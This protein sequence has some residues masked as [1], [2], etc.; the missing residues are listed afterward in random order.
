MSNTIR[1]RRRIVNGVEITLLEK[2]TDTLPL[3]D[4]TLVYSNIESRLKTYLTEQLSK[5]TLPQSVQTIVQQEVQSAKSLLT[6]PLFVSS[7]LT[8]TDIIATVSNTPEDGSV[9]AY[10]SQGSTLVWRQSPNVRLDIIDNTL[11]NYPNEFI[12]DH[13]TSNKFHIPFAVSWNGNSWGGEGRAGIFW[14]DPWDEPVD[15]YSIKFGRDDS[16]L[17][18]T[19]YTY[20]TVGGLAMKF[21][22]GM[23]FDTSNGRGSPGGYR[24]FVWNRVAGSAQ[25]G[26]Q[27]VMA[28]DS[29]EGNLTVRGRIK[30]DYTGNPIVGNIFLESY[31]PTTD[32]P[33]IVISGVGSS[34]NGYVLTYEQNPYVPYYA[35]LKLKPS[36]GGPSTGGYSTSGGVIDC[37]SFLSTDGIIDCGS[38]I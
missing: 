6:E 1:K 3:V 8:A 30:S 4:S 26:N 22:N 34:Y 28:L 16:S 5:V 17:G 10:D 25:G 36:T 29:K 35:S 9:M 21:S 27:P 23:E 24:G 13:I 7:G 20:G 33:I 2:N 32:N 38:F 12:S 37:G 19:G 18:E 14:L 11:L 15:N 31:D